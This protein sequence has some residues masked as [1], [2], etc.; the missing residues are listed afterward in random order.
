MDLFNIKKS[1]LRQQ[2]FNLYFSHP[3]KKYYLRELERRLKKPVAYIRRELLSLEKTGLFTSEY[4]GKERFFFL[5]KD[6]PLY[7]EMERVVFK[8]IGVE[9]NLRHLFE[10]IKGIEAA[11]IFGSYARGDNDSLSDIDLMIIGNPKE[12]NIID[13]ISALEKDIDREVNY[14]IFSFSEWKQRI[15]R[16]D[17]F[18]GSVIKNSKIYIKGDEK[19]ISKFD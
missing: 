10:E 19:K 14:H 4:S 17:S 18:T 5:N 12:E 1:K 8:T 2:I 15:K 3:E 7:K 9:A 6:F 11:F 13:A 16:K